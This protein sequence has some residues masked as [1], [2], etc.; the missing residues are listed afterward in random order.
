MPK[1]PLDV[2]GENDPALMDEI[3]RAR[4]LALNE[5]ALSLKHKVLI[6]LAIDA[7]QGASEG[8]KNLALQAMELGASR[9]EIMETLRVVNCICGAD[10]MYTAAAG[11]REIW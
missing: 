5:G 6:A 3:N 7:A 4:D 8:V 11:L 10:G 9:A 1:H 2:I